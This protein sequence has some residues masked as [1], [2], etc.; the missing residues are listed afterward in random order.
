MVRSQSVPEDRCR[1]AKGGQSH[2]WSPLMALNTSGSPTYDRAR[3]GQELIVP[4]QS[5]KGSLMILWKSPKG[6]YGRT[7]PSLFHLGDIKSITLNFFFE[8]RIK[9]RLYKRKKCITLR[10]SFVDHI[11]S[12]NDFWFI[13]CMFK[14]IT[15]I[16]LYF[17][18]LKMEIAICQTLEYWEGGN[19][20]LPLVNFSFVHT[21][22]NYLQTNNS[23]IK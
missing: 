11:W 6:G 9:M 10:K 23:L 20:Y 17:L 21:E 16:W 7:C 14:A 8:N 5:Q 12:T 18:V 22:R 3:R 15:W 13:N 4:G 19:E 2:W 1:R